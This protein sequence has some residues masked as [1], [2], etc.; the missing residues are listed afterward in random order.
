MS[1]YTNYQDERFT[2]VSGVDHILGNF[3]QMYDKTMQEETPEGEGLILD[4][5]QGFGVSTNYTGEP[6]G[7]SEREV[8]SAVENYLKENVKNLVV[9]TAEQGFSMN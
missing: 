9:I 8:R 6:I 4:W 2:V 3:I 7:N 5:S 1:R